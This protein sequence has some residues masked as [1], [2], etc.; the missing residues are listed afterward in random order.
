MKIY[1]IHHTTAFKLEE[2]QARHLTERGREQA[3]RLGARFVAA[4]INPVRILYS[5]KQ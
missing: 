2:D 5:D 3:D 1:L 4:G